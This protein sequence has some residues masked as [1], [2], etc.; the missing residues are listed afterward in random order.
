MDKFDYG[1][2]TGWYSVRTQCSRISTIALQTILGK[3]TE[4]ATY[5]I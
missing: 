5:Y 4:K 1:K 3:M 2:T